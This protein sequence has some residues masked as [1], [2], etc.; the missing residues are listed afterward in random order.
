MSIQRKQKK[1]ER[2]TYTRKDTPLEATPTVSDTTLYGRA[3]SMTPE[4][5]TP[6][7]NLPKAMKAQQEKEAQDA[8]KKAKENLDKN[9]LKPLNPRA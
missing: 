7:P 4:Q 8:L 9:F 5:P 3:K 6:Q 2:P 1:E